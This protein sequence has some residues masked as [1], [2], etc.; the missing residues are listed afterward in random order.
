MIESWLF[1]TL[2]VAGTVALAV[3]VI[4]ALDNAD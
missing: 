3:L 4:R 2:F 1:A